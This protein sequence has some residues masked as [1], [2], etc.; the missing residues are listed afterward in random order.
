MCTA[1]ITMFLSKTAINRP[2]GAAARGRM[3]VHYWQEKVLDRSSIC[4]NS[5]SSVEVNGS[6][7]NLQQ[8]SFWPYGSM[9]I[10]S[11]ETYPIIIDYFL[12]H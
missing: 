2:E 9:D 7:T 11:P 4:I 3:V 1:E 5:C 12:L 8:L 6:K 10:C